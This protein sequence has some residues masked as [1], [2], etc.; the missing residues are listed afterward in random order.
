V[1]VWFDKIKAG[2]KTIEVRRNTGKFAT[3]ETGNIILFRGLEPTDKVRAKVTGVRKYAKTKLKDSNS[4]KTD[5]PVGKLLSSETISAVFPGMKK[6]EG[7][8]ELERWGDIPDEG[9]IAIKF[10]ILEDRPPKDRKPKVHSKHS[11]SDQDVGKIMEAAL[12]KQQN[13]PVP[14]A[15]EPAGDANEESS[16]SGAGGFFGGGFYDDKE[17]SGKPK[18]KKS[19]KK[20]AKKSAA[21]KPAKKSTKKPAKKKST[22]K[23]SV[24]KI[25][26]RI[27]A[28]TKVMSKTKK[29]ASDL[30]SYFNQ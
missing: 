9:L 22:V 3:V 15:D 2:K 26:A 18:K 11:P 29:T 25:K 14:N 20:P 28:A 10:R 7:R 27:K 23:K 13:E 12:L 19:A 8:G 21:K 24:D 6:D 5:D 4:V 16:A 17:G 1:K 30:N